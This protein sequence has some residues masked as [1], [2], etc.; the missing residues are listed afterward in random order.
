LNSNSGQFICFTFIFVSLENHICLSHGVQV[1]VA[2]WCATMRI[3]VGVGDLVQ[4]TEDS[5]TG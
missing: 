5:R 3:M 4:R 2:A 1:A